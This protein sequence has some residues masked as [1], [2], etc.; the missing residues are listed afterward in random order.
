MPGWGRGGGAVIVVPVTL[1]W[2]GLVGRSRGQVVWVCQ[3]V[4]MPISGYASVLVSHCGCTGL[5]GMSVLWPCNMCGCTK[6]CI[7]QF[8]GVMFL[9]MPVSW[10]AS[11]VCQSCCCIVLVDSYAAT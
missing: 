1:H 9:G 3:C 10:Y 6:L 11:P 8:L 5:V 4:R 2:T 7:C